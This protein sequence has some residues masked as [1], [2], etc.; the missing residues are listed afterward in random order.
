MP[1][2]WARIH[3]T[4]GSA[5][6]SAAE[7][8]GPGCFSTSDLRNRELIGVV[9]VV[10][11]VGQT[12]QRDGPQKKR[13]LLDSPTTN[14]FPKGTC[15]L[16]DSRLLCW[17]RHGLDAVL[18]RLQNKTDEDISNTQIK[19]KSTKHWKG[20]Y[21]YIYTYISFFPKHLRI[22]HWHVYSKSTGQNNEIMD[23]MW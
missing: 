4:I 6:R 1:V 11:V 7:L 17:H 10:E 18:P 14:P 8:A 13:L 9:Q 20:Y 3:G 12:G 2:A 16:E 5:I 23:H 21:I 19:S 22:L 15:W